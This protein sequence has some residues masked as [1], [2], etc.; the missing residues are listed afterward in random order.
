MISVSMLIEVFAG[1]FQCMDT[2]LN[3]EEQVGDA[4]SQNT[5]LLDYV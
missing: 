2:I 5:T 1:R 4:S 3:Y